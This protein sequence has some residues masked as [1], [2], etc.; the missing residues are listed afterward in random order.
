MPLTAG[1]D[2]PDWNDGAGLAVV[3]DELASGQRLAVDQPPGAPG[4]TAAR[5]EDILG[6]EPF[7]ELPGRDAGRPR[8]GRV[9]VIGRW[10]VQGQGF[11]RD[12]FLEFLDQPGLLDLLPLGPMVQAAD[13]DGVVRQV[14]QRPLAR[15][16]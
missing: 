15:R 7:R 11:A 12:Q 14:Q 5:G 1:P 10:G 3:V 8:C 9:V 2:K 6:D 16:W 4:A 13:N